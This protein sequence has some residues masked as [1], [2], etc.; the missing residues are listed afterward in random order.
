LSCR[1]N[2]SHGDRRSR[3][4]CEPI[5]RPGCSKLIC[6]SRLHAPDHDDSYVRSKYAA[7]DVHAPGRPIDRLT[8]RAHGD[9][10]WVVLSPRLESQEPIKV[11]R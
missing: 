3:G 7:S 1:W 8:G 6:C 5:E 10:S 4:V 9:V 2:A 11:L